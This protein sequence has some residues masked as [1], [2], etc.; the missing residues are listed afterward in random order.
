M[1][2][3]LLNDDRWHPGHI[4]REGVRPLEAQ[5]YAFDV[6]A[7]GAAIP[8]I[9]FSQYDAILFVKSDNRTAEDTAKWADEAVRGKLT[10]YVQ[11][12]GGLLAVHSGTAG[13]GGLEDMHRLLGGLFMIH[14]AQ[15][16]VTFTPAAGHP[17]A[18]GVQ[19]FTEV[20]EHYLMD[21]AEGPADMFLTGTSRHGIIPAGWT[22]T[23]GNGRVCVLTPGHNLDVWLNPNF[24]QLLRNALDWCAGA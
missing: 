9:D 22:R 17:L 20:D 8:A 3:L 15:L 10:Q 11:N 6:V 2:I 4:S 16:P 21:M 14:P 1:K 24:Q 18:A 5:G 7:D 23:E 19:A 12:G 13:Y